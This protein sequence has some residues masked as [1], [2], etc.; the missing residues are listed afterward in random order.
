MPSKTKEVPQ[1]TP[2]Q[3]AEELGLK[4]GKAVRAFLRKSFARAAE[5]KGS[6]WTLAANGPE[7]K[8]VRERFTPKPAEQKAS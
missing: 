1:V 6:R 7:A 3:L 2:E 8:A 4:N 5:A